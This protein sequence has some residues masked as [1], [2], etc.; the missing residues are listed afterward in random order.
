MRMS[1]WSQTGALPIFIRI[2]PIAIACFMFNLAAL[3]GWD[4]LVRLSAYV[5]VVLLALGVQMIVVF[6]VLLVMLA[7]KSP[8]LFF[9]QVQEAMVMA[10]A[11][12]SSHAPLPTALRVHDKA[13]N[14]PPKFARLVLTIGAITTPNGPAT[15][16]VAPVYFL[17]QFFGVTLFFGQ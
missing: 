6:S 3:F 9:R 15:F 2:A 5:G 11:T 8:L 16:A 13:L 12:A 4:L 17:A 10:F 7:K 1:D 14:L